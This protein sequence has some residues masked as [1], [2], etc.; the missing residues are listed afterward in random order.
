MGNY[1]I[2]DTS[3]KEMVVGIVK[4]N[5]LIY[6]MQKYAFQRQSEIAV[7]EVEKAFK[8]TNLNPKDINK[9]IVTYGP[10]SYTGVRIALTIAKVFC[11]SLKIELVP[12]TSLQALS[13]AKGK[14]IALIDARSNMAYYSVFDNGVILE[15]ANIIK[16]EKLNELLEKYENFEVVGDTFLIGKENKEI[17]IVSN[18]FELSLITKGVKE[19]DNV[20]PLYLK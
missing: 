16:I 19:V 5:Q 13:G 10:G 20:N 15:N 4:D 3:F 1:L 6:K 14:K 11:S 12:L 7:Q 9:V 2:L 18:M 17:D 8:E